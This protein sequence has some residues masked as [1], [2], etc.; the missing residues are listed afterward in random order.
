MHKMHQ[1][2]NVHTSTQQISFVCV[3]VWMGVV[4]AEWKW[5]LIV[6]F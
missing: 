1:T 3:H 2:N 5:S 4:M 6:G